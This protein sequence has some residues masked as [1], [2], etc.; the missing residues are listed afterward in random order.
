M[1]MDSCEQGGKKLLDWK[2]PV[3]GGA[4]LKH[5]QNTSVCMNEI[6]LNIYVCVQPLSLFYSAIY[7]NNFFSQFSNDF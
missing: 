1:T 7:V 5:K 3:L 6:V 2:F 4:I